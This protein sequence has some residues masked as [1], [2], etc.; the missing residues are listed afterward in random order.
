MTDFQQISNS[1]HFPGK[2]ENS[3]DNTNIQIWQK[4]I[5]NKL[6]AKFRQFGFRK[7]HSIDHAV[8]ELISLKLT[9]SNYK[10]CTKNEVFH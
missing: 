6:S 1:W 9:L 10:H 7:A 4:I 2:Y 8:I 3:K 5:T